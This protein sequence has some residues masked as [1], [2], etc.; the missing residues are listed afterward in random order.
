MSDSTT[1][2][3]CLLD[4]DPSVL[5]AVGRLLASAGLVVE[6]FS[7]ALPFLSYISTN[8]VDLVVLDIW[9][10]HMSGLEVLAHM[11][12]LSPHTPIVIIT[13]R[14]DI[15]VKAIA[16]QVGVVGYFLKPFDDEEFLAAV[17]H[18]LGARRKVKPKPDDVLRSF[19]AGR[20]LRE[21]WIA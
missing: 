10:K 5:K 2:V 14:E 8:G 13:G 15:A 1:S 7:E 3:I 16:T 20:S 12:S 11:C 6:V 18:A 17:R 4:D 21:N 9:M 19:A